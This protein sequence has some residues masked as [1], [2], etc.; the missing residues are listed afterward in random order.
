MTRR[1]SLVCGLLVAV[2]ASVV[3][4]AVSERA[5][6][7]TVVVEP[8]TVVEDAAQPVFSFHDAYEQDA[9][10]VV[11]ITATGVSSA[12]STAELVKGE[13][14]EQSTATGSGFEV[15][16]D[17]T[18]LTN[19][20]VVQ[21]STRIFVSLEEGSKALE[22]HIVGDDPS[23]DVALLSV[24][25]GGLTLHPLPLGISNR[26]QVGEPVLAI[27]DPFGYART[28]TTGVISARDRRIEAPDGATITDA[29]QTDTPI[30]P[31]NSGGPLL[32]TEGQVIGINSQIVTSGGE[33]GS[34]G[35]AF[36][37]PIDTVARE[38]PAL[39]RGAR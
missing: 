7:T 16:A 24:P 19:W 6:Q 25:A 39:A 9:P 34:V 29:L 32:N 1:S 28:L 26:M 3:V 33:G 23:L 11:A 36:A 8:R 4:W 27:G 35:L 38:M 18:I 2:G 13:G 17:G 12:P 20:H 22:A 14:D 21:G 30:N 37:I 15:G 5:S 10:G 31:G